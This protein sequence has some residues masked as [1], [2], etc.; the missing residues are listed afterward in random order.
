MYRKIPDRRTRQVNNWCY[1]HLY[2]S[3]RQVNSQLDVQ[4][5]WVQ[6]PN[7]SIETSEPDPVRKEDEVLILAS[8]GKVQTHTLFSAW[9][10]EIVF[11]MGTF[12]YALVMVKRLTPR[13]QEL[14][15]LT[16]YYQIL[17]NITN[18]GLQRE[19]FLHLIKEN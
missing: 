5:N 3:E 16:G 14:T 7:T 6:I 17:Q 11:P 13:L 4:R 1:W 2:H 12:D 9:C 18:G 15:P 8:L 19:E 10:K